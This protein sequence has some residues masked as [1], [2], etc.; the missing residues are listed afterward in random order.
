MAL[1]IASDVGR[2]S[3][4][5]DERVRISAMLNKIKLMIS[6]IRNAM[7]I[8]P[9]SQPE[10]TVG[11]IRVRL[12]VLDVTETVETEGS[13]KW[14]METLFKRNKKIILKP[15][16]ECECAMRGVS[17]LVVIRHKE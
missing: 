13:G 14:M 12:V 3:N 6:P 1:S 9:T 2:Y 15:L 10:S 16:N 7:C 11:W 4:G 5:D 8:N 17:G